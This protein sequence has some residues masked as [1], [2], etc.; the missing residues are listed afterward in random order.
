MPRRRSSGELPLPN[1]WEEARD[2]DGRVFY[3]DHNTR[4][5]SWIDPRDSCPL[6]VLLVIESKH[7]SM[8][9][10]THVSHGL[11][12]EVFEVRLE[13]Y[14]AQVS[15]FRRGEQETGRGKE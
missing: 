13:L 5:T 15:N 10:A 3:I 11:L 14:A 9:L 4:Q 2:F 12:G 7:R 1:G 6:K 8:N